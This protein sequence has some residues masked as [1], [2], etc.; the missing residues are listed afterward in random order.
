MRAFHERLAYSFV[1][2]SCLMHVFCCGLPLMMSAANVAALLGITGAGLAH[3]L[4][5]EQFEVTI[6]IVSGVMLAITA[7]LQAISKRINCRTTGSCVHEPCD[8]KK[9]LS[10]RAFQIAVVLYVVNVALFALSH[11][12]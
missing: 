6:M 10:E 4:W 11:H 7:L 2:G 9:S 1:I 3:S 8:K 5:F 12:A